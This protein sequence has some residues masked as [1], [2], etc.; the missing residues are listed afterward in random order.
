MNTTIEIAAKV[1]E[2]RNDGA[3]S[4]LSN[5]RDLLARFA[6]DVRQA[7]LIGEEVN[8]KV[9]FLAAVSAGLAKPLNVSVHGRS[10]AGKNCLTGTVA[11]FIPDERKKMLSGMSPKALMHSAEDEFEH[12][13][14]FIAEYEGV[15]GADYAMRTFQSEH[16]ITWEFVD[17]VQGQG[18]KKQ[19]RHVRGP[20]AFIQATTR[21]TLHPENE[22]RLL[23]VEVDESREQT[24]AINERQ[25]REAAGEIGTPDTGV[26]AE[27]HE[28][29]KSLQ[30]TKVIIPFAAQLAVHFPAERI[31]SRRDFPKLLGL[32]EA[33]AFLHQHRREQDALGRIVA[34]P[35]DYRVGKELFEHSYY[36]GPE[37]DVAELVKS[38]AAIE[39]PIPHAY[40][41]FS[42]ADLIQWLGWGQTKVYE[43]L[44][45]AKDIGCIGDADKRGQY[46]F[47]RG[48]TESP[49]DLPPTVV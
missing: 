41:E 30:L 9:V 47:I 16:E 7:G 17:Q 24:R 34:T 21:A 19:N 22:T 25:A 40:K 42:V 33:S 10:S 12:K 3:G 15:A 44:S 31:R 1:G 8:A 39:T 18:L 43:V 2:Y 13:A 37:R 29:I 28:L 27:W 36:A 38:A 48:T 11:R 23:F 14:V 4:N 6:H 32:I 35:E 45:R 49:L 46:R 26:F 20:A 5:E